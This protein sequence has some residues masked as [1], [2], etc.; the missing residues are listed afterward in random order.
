MIER[1][2]YNGILFS[3]P[4]LVEVTAT[5]IKDAAQPTIAYTKYELVI[6]AV[7]VYDTPPE[8][9]KLGTDVRVLLTR[10][11]A[12][13]DVEDTGFGRILV[14]SDS[15]GPAWQD[16]AGGPFPELLS[17]SPLG[18]TQAAEVT[19]KVTAC[20]NDC[21]SARV[22]DILGFHYE[23]TTELDDRG[24]TVRT[25]S[26]E[27]RMVPQRRGRQILTSADK[28][29][30]SLKFPVPMGFRRQQQ[31]YKVSSDKTTLSFTL[32]DQQVDSPN[33]FPPGVTHID[34][35]HTV[36]WN[37]KKAAT[38]RG[39]LTMNVTLAVGEPR[40]RAYQIFLD[41]ARKRLGFVRSRS[42]GIL[43]DSVTATEQLFSH[44]ASFSATWRILHELK[45]LL[46]N[47]GFW[48]P[49]ET[50][51][52]Q[53]AKS[54]VVPW[55]NRGVAFLFVDGPV[56]SIVDQC[57]GDILI[58]KEKSLEPSYAQYRTTALKNEKPDPARSYLNYRLSVEVEEDSRHAKQAPAQSSSGPTDPGA[59]GY[60]PYQ[61]AWDP[62]S[63]EPQNY[64]PP[65]GV[66]DTIQV[67]GRPVYKA[68]VRGLAVR[69][70]Y[71]IAKP[72]L[73]AIGERTAIEVKSRFIQESLGD[74]LGVTVYRAA[75]DI[76][77]ELTNSPGRTGP[78]DNPME[79]QNDTSSI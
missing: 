39:S 34:C 24:L 65:V 10:P 58:P 51:W 17:W 76:T 47:S 79:A 60:Q 35:E 9:D 73:T 26:G 42:K 32:V 41:I 43:L 46:E 70:A 45:D 77:Y 68:R 69:A 33:A 59:P 74:F 18:G 67:A 40:A 2:T 64:G 22:R 37:R 61:G 75:W 30:D 36:A 38:P 31:T 62:G 8:L 19:W 27:V 52:K 78:P 56:G 57:G 3:R 1:V 15:G 21:P 4:S 6:T 55:S 72:R 20:F 66:D 28:Y 50:D 71:P 49:L 63:P 16:V 25:V 54:L 5:P 44:D 23:S 29:R 48:R 11:G 53:W 12:I 14:S 13:L 7:V